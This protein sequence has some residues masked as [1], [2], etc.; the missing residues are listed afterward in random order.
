MYKYLLAVA[1][2][3]AITLAGMAYAMSAALPAPRHTDAACMRLW[4]MQGVPLASHAADHVG[5]YAGC[6][7]A[8]RLGTMV[9]YGRGTSYCDRRAYRYTFTRHLTGT[10]FTAAMAGK[11]VLYEDW[12]WGTE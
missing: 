5:N 7:Q 1:L 2:A 9:G 3:A 11:C 12:A 8:Y 4:A 6:Q 10:A